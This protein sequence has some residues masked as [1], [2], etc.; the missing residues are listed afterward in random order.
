MIV[1]C[2]GSSDEDFT[3]GGTYEL[4]VIKNTRHSVNYIAEVNDNFGEIR[5]HTDLTSD[6]SV[7]NAT[8]GFV[9]DSN[10]K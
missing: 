1:R 3:V 6:F 2:L 9:K 4:N 5:V 8:L 10:I 7:G